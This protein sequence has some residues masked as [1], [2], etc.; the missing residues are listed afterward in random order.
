MES[1]I[2]DRIDRLQIIIDEWLHPGNYDLKEAIDKTVNERFF[3]FEDIKH[4]LLV[5]KKTLNKRDLLRWAEPLKRTLS[6][7]K[8]K[9]ILCLH[10]GNIPLVGLQDLLAVLISGD[11]Y[12]GK[13]SRKDP[14]LLPTILKKLQREGFVK[15]DEWSTDLAELPE[16]SADAVLFSGSTESV[17]VVFNRLVSL[18][19]VKKQTPALVRT[20]HFSIAF[21]EDS[22]PDTMDQLTQAVLRYGGKGCRSVAMVVAPFS[23]HSQKCHFTDYI[24]KFFLAVPQHEKA[25]PSLYQRY[26]YNKSVGIE[27]AWL[28]NFLI[29]E[30]EME[31]SEPFILHWVKGG[32]DTLTKLVDRYKNGLQT[33]YVKDPSVEIEGIETE[34]L[35]DAQQPP[36]YWKPD[37]VNAISWL[38]N[39]D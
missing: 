2:E 30:T 20:A 16:I 25:P 7:Q 34:L 29:E 33:V 32:K 36:I 38:N 9:R 18:K 23:L 10:A 4:Q 13:I 19:L 14:Y 3:S 35:I 31:P 12:T 24:E 11:H 21:I 39:L 22:L 15:K 5:F 27:Q 26:A 37:R 17:D 28:D 6:N 8:K 1:E